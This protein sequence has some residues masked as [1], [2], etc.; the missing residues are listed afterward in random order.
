MAITLRSGKEL[1]SINE[2]EMKKTKAK[3]EKTYHN[4]TINGKKL[5]RNRLFYETKHIKEQ[6]EVAKD[7]VVQKEEVRIYQPPT[8]FPQIL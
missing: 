3:T 2:T 7:E 4:S 5:N 6:S 1:K 8:S